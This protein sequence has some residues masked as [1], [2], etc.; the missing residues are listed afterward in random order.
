MK[1][2]SMALKIRINDIKAQ[3]NTDVCVFPLSFLPLVTLPTTSDHRLVENNHHHLT[4]LC[5]QNF[6]LQSFNDV[7]IRASYI[8][9]QVDPKDYIISFRWRWNDND[10]VSRWGLWL[11]DLKKKGQSKKRVISVCRHFK[12]IR[13]RHQYQNI[14]A[15]KTVSMWVAAECW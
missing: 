15:H 13:R 14:C 4:S 6:L 3:N 5:F 12:N 2:S 7:H 11:A 9:L 8:L 10:D 1:Y